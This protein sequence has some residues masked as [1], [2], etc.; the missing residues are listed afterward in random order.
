MFEA[1]ASKD[2]VRE[3]IFIYLYYIFRSQ[4]YPQQGFPFVYD[5]YQLCADNVRF[6]TPK[7]DDYYFDMKF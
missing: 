6:R 3:L 7:T 5:T 1:C 2:Q 4:N